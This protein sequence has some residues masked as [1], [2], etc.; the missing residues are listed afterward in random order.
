[1]LVGGWMSIVTYSYVGYLNDMC[2]VVGI[3]T[4]I[5]LSTCD[6]ICMNR[7]GSLDGC[8]SLYSTDSEDNVS[9]LE[10]ISSFFNKPPVPG[11]WNHLCDIIV[12]FLRCQESIVALINVLSC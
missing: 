11:P 5:V 4:T 7:P 6:F 10:G 8:Y 9:N 2:S 1:M 12:L 3:Q